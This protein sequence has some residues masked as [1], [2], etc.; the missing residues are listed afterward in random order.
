M[1][2]HLELPPHNWWGGLD[3]NQKHTEFPIE[4]SDTTASHYLLCSKIKGGENND[5]R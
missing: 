3:L 2:Y 4:V 5:F 1:L